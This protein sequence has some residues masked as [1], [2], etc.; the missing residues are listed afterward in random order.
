VLRPKP[1]RPI[2]YFIPMG[3]KARAKAFILTTECRHKGIGADIEL[4]GKKMQAAIQNAI[5][6]DAHYCAII[7]DRELEQGILQLKDL[8]TREQ[9]EIRFENLV[10]EIHRA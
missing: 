3:E 9:R 5:R 7:G 1:Y 4:S 8:H 10:E 2:I 6:L